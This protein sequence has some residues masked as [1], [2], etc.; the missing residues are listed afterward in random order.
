MHRPLSAPGFH[1][2]DLPMAQLL[3]V[4]D[5]AITALALWRAVTRLGHQVVARTATA[6]DA[7]AAVQAYRPDA[8][9]LDLRL[10][11]PHDGFIVGTDIQAL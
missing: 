1:G 9:L 6:A 3:I 4:E 5:D 2:E 11:A 8:V 10:P 7:M